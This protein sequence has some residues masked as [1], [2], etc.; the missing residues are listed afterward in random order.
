M[1][2]GSAGVLGLEHH[3]FCLLT[4]ATLARLHSWSF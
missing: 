4:R 1:T 2:V 3:D